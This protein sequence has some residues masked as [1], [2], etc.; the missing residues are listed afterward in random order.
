MRSWYPL[1]GTSRSLPSRVG[2]GGLKGSTCERSLNAN[3]R[4]VGGAS[5]RGNG[6][7]RLPGTGT[8]LWRVR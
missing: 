1:R 4:G 2:G 8:G 6:V 3:A 7:Q 5:D